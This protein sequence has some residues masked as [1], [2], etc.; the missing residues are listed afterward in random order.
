MA[1]SARMSA[2]GGGIAVELSSLRQAT[3]SVDID[4]FDTL[5]KDASKMLFFAFFNHKASGLKIKL[6]PFTESKK[7]R[8]A[9]FILFEGP[10]KVGKT[11]LAK[12]LAEVL[13]EDGVRVV[14]RR[15]PDRSAPITGKIIDGYLKGEI[16]LNVE[17]AHDLFVEN[18]KECLSRL[19][20][21]LEGYNVVICD[22]C[23]PSGAVYSKTKGMTWED[24]L[25][26]DLDLNQPVPDVLVKVSADIEDVC[27]RAGF[28]EEIGEEREF[29]EQVQ[30]NFEEF[31][32]F[33]LLV[34]DF[35]FSIV[36]DN[37]TSTEGHVQWLKRQ[38]DA[39]IAVNWP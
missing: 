10:D 13:N 14:S 11:T 37:H 33:E 18:R 5:F 1:K 31:Y 26:G 15:Y 9:L 34:C 24:S 36:N 25:K 23:W 6:T 3:K 21:D 28:G 20:E 22:R 32:K 8:K 29:Q 17:K 4:A 7:E 27:K 16:K 30:K 38:V 35:N 19:E 12:R 39:W 2:C